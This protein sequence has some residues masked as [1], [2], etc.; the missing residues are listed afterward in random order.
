MSNTVHDP[1]SAKQNMRQIAVV[2]LCK[3]SSRRGDRSLGRVVPGRSTYRILSDRETER[4]GGTARRKLFGCSI[5][6][7]DEQGQNYR[8][9]S[10]G[11]ALSPG[12]F[13]QVES[14]RELLMFSWSQVRVH[15][16]IFLP[17]QSQDCQI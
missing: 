9:G 5:L 17:I 14:S 1:E 6:V 15:L 8:P 7:F 12:G 4:L 11:S 3:N 16:N 10:T 2:L 13:V